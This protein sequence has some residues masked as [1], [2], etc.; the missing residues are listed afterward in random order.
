[1]N[2]WISVLENLHY[3]ISCP[4]NYGWFHF[5]VIFISLAVGVLLCVTHKKGD[6][7]RVRRVVLIVAVIVA[8]LEIYKQVVYTFE[9]SDGAVVADF[10]WYAF[11]WQFCS[12]PMYVGL[13]TAI[14]KKGRIHDALCAYLATYAVFAGVCV[15]AYPGDVFSPIAGISLQ[16]SVCHGSMLSV[17][18]YLWYSGYV[19]LSKRMLLG[20]A[21]VFSCAVGVAVLLNETA[22]HSG[23]IGDEI[24]NMF[25]VSPHFPPSLPVY[26]AVQASL[27]YPL[28]LVIYILVFSFAACLM[29]FSAEGIRRLFTKKA[30][31]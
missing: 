4:K 16:T 1:M 12:T 5:A 10:Q 15:M 9:V 13:L 18:I 21:A 17:G 29:A 3:Q 2:F 24:F 27:P 25:F 14:F 11:P 8:I 26:S 7:R 28:D 6:D 31:A 23:I 30:F 19:K 20:G 22:F